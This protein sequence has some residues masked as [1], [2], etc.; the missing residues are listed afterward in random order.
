MLWGLECGWGW[1]VRSVLS[2][3][4][5]RQDDLPPDRHL[6]CVCYLHFA[7]ENTANTFMALKSLRRPL[8]GSPRAGNP[9]ITEGGKRSTVSPS[10]E[11]VSSWQSLNTQATPTNLFVKNNFSFTNQS[12]GTQNITASSGTLAEK[13]Y[14]K[15]YITNFSRNMMSQH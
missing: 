2:R 4:F 14:S 10:T 3:D 12:M 13:T 8:G 9:G 11:E 15:L 5:R 1:Q 6:A 7:A